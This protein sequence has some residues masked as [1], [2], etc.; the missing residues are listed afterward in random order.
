MRLLVPAMVLG[1]LALTGCFLTSGQVLV[2]YDMPNPV[3][4]VNASP[5]TGVYVDLNT[6]SEYQDHKDNVKNISDIALLGTIRNNTANPI[7][8]EVWLVDGP[9]QVLTPDQVQAQ[10]TR[11]WGPLAVAGN[12]TTTI[13]WNESAKLF[14][15]GKSALLDQVKGDG[16]FSLYILAPTGTYDFD[17]EHGVLAL[18]IGAGI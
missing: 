12:A 11:V 1:A 13:D 5:A 3:H 10:G 9:L 7:Q 18:V 17:L 6:I 8:C 14:G 15:A 2:K 4:V 16:Q